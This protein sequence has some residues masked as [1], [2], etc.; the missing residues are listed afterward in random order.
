MMVVPQPMPDEIARSILGRIMR[1]NSLGRSKGIDAV[2]VL[3]SFIG[4]SASEPRSTVG[5]IA[6]ILGR[7]PRDFVEQHTLL[8]WWLVVCRQNCLE[9]DGQLRFSSLA[10]AI[11]PQRSY[12][13]LCPACVSEDLQFHG[14]SYWRR[15]HQ[16]D[17]AYECSKHGAAL[18]HYTGIDTV[19][20]APSEALQRKPL[21]VS[22]S[23]RA[24]ERSVQALI[25]DLGESKVS[26]PKAIVLARLKRRLADQGVVST[27]QQHL[28]KIQERLE[29]GFSQEWMR[30]TT[31]AFCRGEGQVVS[32]GVTG[33]FNHARFGRT[34]Y[35]FALAV[36]LLNRDQDPFSLFAIPPSEFEI[37]ASELRRRALRPESLTQTY[38]E[39]K[40]RY[41]DVLPR[42]VEQRDACRGRLAELGLPDLDGR[43]FEAARLFYVE[44]CS[45]GETVQKT[46][47]DLEQF[48]I[49]LR[50]AGESLR[51]ACK[52]MESVARDPRASA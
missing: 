25:T 22:G 15:G 39:R 37:R 10:Q 24:A 8:P 29:E 44:A 28:V 6:Q 26:I 45:I 31:P 38:I 35:A 7:A 1:W 16:L 33:F 34:T 23:L 42:Q 51:R 13:S 49:M 46:G 41:A 4:A 17:G 21:K 14:F 52:Q 20:T 12:V 2:K 36:A 47:V 5:L 3:R 11:Q 18:H 9:E 32:R 27:E 19:Q 50:A 48:E 40:G 30:E 43:M